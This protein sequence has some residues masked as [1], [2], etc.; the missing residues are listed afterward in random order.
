MLHKIWAAQEN[1]YI[2]AE[3]PL[4]RCNDS[5]LNVTKKKKKRSTKLIIRRRL[6]HLALAGG[7]RAVR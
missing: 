1:W 7:I 4:K 3:Q 5:V 6:T 2:E